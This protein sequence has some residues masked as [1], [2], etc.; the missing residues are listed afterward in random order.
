MNYWARIAAVKLLCLTGI[1]WEIGDCYFGLEH[2]PDGA[3]LH[4]TVA[5]EPFHKHC[6]Q[7]AWT[8]LMHTTNLTHLLHMGLIDVSSGTGLEVEM[9]SLWNKS[10]IWPKK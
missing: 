8:P 6:T 3:C 7:M 10:L 4:C 5:Q 2:Y 1:Q 9:G